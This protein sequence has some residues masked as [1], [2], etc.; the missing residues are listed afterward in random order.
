MDSCVFVYRFT[1][2]LPAR[3][4][5]KPLLSQ[6]LPPSLQPKPPSPPSLPPLDASHRHR[7][8]CCPQAD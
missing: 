8:S 7:R 5:L 3:S 6:L 4:L 1:P 2:T